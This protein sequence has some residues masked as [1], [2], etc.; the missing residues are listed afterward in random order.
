MVG[1]RFILKNG[2]KERR[3]IAEA[4]LL[5]MSPVQIVSDCAKYEMIVVF[6]CE[7]EPLHCSSLCGYFHP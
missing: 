4:G 3:A 1:N 6:N 2:Y 5:A 7:T